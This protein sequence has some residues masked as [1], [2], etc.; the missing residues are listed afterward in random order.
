MA[1][2]LLVPLITKHKDEHKTGG[3]DAFTATDLLEALVKRI[4]E[5]GGA[6]LLVGAVADGEF[7]KRSGTSLVG[8]S[9]GGIQGTWTQLGTGLTTVANNTEVTVLAGQA[10][11]V[12]EIP[13][14]WAVMETTPTGSAH[15]TVNGRT[16]A[17]P[18]NLQMVYAPV[19]K[20]DGNVDFRVRHKDGGNR[21]IRWV[22]Y[23]V[24]P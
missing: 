6:D 23:K 2:R 21:D 17:D 22:A 10:L 14:M 4:R 8:A 24:L 5:S 9:A 18:S 7:L 19:K 11:A 1:E 16:D 3:F 13:V 20:L 12:G 15:S